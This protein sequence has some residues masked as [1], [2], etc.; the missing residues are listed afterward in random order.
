MVAAFLA[1]LPPAVLSS[2]SEFAQVEY[3]IIVEGYAKPPGVPGKDKTTADRIML[4]EYITNTPVTLTA[5][6]TNNEGISG[7]EFSQVIGAAV[8]TW[9]KATNAELSVDTI[10]TKTGSGR[11]AG[12]YINSVYFADLDTG[13]IAMASVWYVRSTREILDCDIQ[14]NTDFVWGDASVDKTK[15]DLQNIAT[16]E[17]GHFFNLADIHDSTK[18]CLTHVRLLR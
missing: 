7:S 13:D 12:D 5:Y 6:T 4:R 8:E 17:L 2:Q 16:H 14:F 3:T 10:E 1:A 9:D 15:M 11:V 18:S